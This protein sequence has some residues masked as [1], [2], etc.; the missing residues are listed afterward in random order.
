[1]PLGPRIRG[2][3][4]RTQ[5]EKESSLPRSITVRSGPGEIE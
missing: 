2:H 5:L 3:Y 4:A 1:M